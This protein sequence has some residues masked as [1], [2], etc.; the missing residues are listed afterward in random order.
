MAPGMDDSSESLSFG[1]RYSPVPISGFEDSGSQGRSS[2]TTESST[3]DS[4]SEEPSLPIPD[5]DLNRPFIAEGVPS[6]LI[7]KDIG[8][9]R[10]CYQISENIVIRLLENGKWAC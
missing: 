6:K 7:D 9:M 8:R 3:S 5:R 4:L 10:R 2:E 1:E